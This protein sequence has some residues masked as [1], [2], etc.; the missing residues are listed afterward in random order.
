MAETL[1]AIGAIVAIAMIAE[2]KK[3][4]YKI[5]KSHRKIWSRQWLL[6][7]YSG[8]D[9]SHIVMKELQL[10]DPNSFLNFC[11]LSKENFEVLLGLVGPQICKQNTNMRESI[12]PTTR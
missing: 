3:N 9:L 1:N 11:R 5:K 2:Y 7:R 6:R 12:S 4:K 8:K 10:E